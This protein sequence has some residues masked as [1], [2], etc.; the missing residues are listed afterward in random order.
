MIG[1][2]PAADDLAGAEPGETPKQRTDRELRELLEEL[3]VALPG[4]QLLLGFLLI[5]PFNTRFAETTP[6]ERGVYLACFVLTAG[7]IAVFIAP[8]AHHR[9]GFRRI[10]KQQLIRRT[11]RLLVGG[12]AAVAVAIAL[13]GYLVTTVVISSRWAAL[14][15]AALAGWFAAWWFAVPLATARRRAR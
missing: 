9:L 14:I 5:L 13:A 10:D 12:L 4:V 1:D 7:A 8:A 15:A 6:F 2:D 11:N 3:R